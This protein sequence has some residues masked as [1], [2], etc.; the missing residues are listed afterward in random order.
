MR[1]E[2]D[3]PR[4]RRAFLAGTAAAILLRCKPD[5]RDCAPGAG[6]TGAGP[7]DTGSPWPCEDPFA[8]GALVG[9]VVFLGE[10]DEGVG[11]VDGSGLD[12]R[13]ALD[14]T[15][16]DEEHLVQTNDAFYLRT[17]APSTLDP[18]G[19]TIPITGLVAAS[20]A[21][22]A[23]ELVAAAVPMGVT[24]LECSGNSLNRAFGLIS[25]ADWSGVLVADV[26]ARVKALPS[27]T[28][29]RIRGFDDH[30]KSTGS[31]AGAAWVFTVDELVAA[32]AFF[33]TEMNGAPLPLDHGGPVRLVVPGWF[34]CTCIKWVDEIAFVDDSEPATSQMVEF[35]ERTHQ[36]GTP[37]LARD[38]KPAK[39]QQAAM[40]VRV[41]QW[42]VAGETVY[43]IVGVL[44]GG[45]TPTDK[46]VVSF[47]G[48]PRAPVDVC[49]A[50]A[51]N[52]TWTLWSTVW[53]PGPGMYTITCHIDDDVPQVRLDDGY[54]ARVVA[55][56]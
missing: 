33:A 13:L 43:R 35:A 55:V 11:Y 17:L 52:R 46:L 53:R 39:I 34:G 2:P 29:V 54:Y 22:T 49:P 10:D 14:L 9:L 32:G 26:L 47:N 40:P 6:D 1:Y 30:P 18:E 19:W 25:A 28:R 4:S 44:W 31:V 23:A 24:L 5:P 8:G 7:E 41:E 36:D 3:P 37:S 42:D 20:S 56:P 50:A 21:I 15:T 16:L 27:A 12:G 38:Y 45:D 48:G 51:T